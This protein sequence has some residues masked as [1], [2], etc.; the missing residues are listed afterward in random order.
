MVLPELDD[1]LEL[2]DELLLDDELELD[3]EDE[4]LEEELD[5]LLLDEE[6]LLVPPPCPP[7]AESISPRLANPTIFKQP[8]GNLISEKF[9]IMVGPIRKFQQ[10]RQTSDRPHSPN[11]RN[12]TGT[13]H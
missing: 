3:E 8:F 5:E 4:E 7:Q 6:L 13:S 12:F 10:R 11:L 2:E 1:E 9:R